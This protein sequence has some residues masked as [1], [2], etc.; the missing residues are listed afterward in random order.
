[1]QTLFELSGVQHLHEALARRE[2][3]THIGNTAGGH[4]FGVG[5]TLAAQLLAAQLNLATGSEYC[6][7]SD[8]AVSQ[9]QLL[10]LKLNFDGTSG[11]L[12]PPLANENVTNAK[13]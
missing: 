12:D 7:A 13:N 9:A 2:K 10:L 3:H 4:V 6:P 1:M 5:F 11:Y 8:Q